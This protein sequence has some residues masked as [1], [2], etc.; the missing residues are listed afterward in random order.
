M[1]EEESML[2][3]LKA[4]EMDLE[5]LLET[6]TRLEL[7]IYQVNQ[8]LD[9]MSTRWK[10]LTEKCMETYSRKD[11][12]KVTVYVCEIT[13]LRIIIKTVVKARLA[14]EY[15]VNGLARFG[16]IEEDKTLLP[17]LAK[18][19]HLAGKM[20]T[21]L[22]LG[23]EDELSGIKRAINAIADETHGKDTI[24]SYA[25]F[26]KE[27]VKKILDVVSPIAEQEVKEKFK[28]PHVRAR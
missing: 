3:Y 4:S 22:S 14:L 2:T 15:V 1:L 24:Q 25:D 10:Q 27:S 23:I 19:V 6:R 13:E 18:V 17:V 12:A 5:I 16:T 21:N 9:S 28:L 7:I 20:T 11:M 26:I 8:E